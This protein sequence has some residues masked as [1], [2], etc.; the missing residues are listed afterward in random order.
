MT[1]TAREEVI[2]FDKLSNPILAE[3][4]RIWDGFEGQLAGM[5]DSDAQSHLKAG[6]P[7]YYCAE[8]LGNRLVREW[9]DGKRDYVGLAE[10]DTVISLGA[11]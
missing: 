4:G 8:E 2:S 1:T 9:P 6:R 10:D 11:V 7:I 3:D 5:D